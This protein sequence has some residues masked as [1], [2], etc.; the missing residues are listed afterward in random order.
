MRSIIL[1]VILTTPFVVT[2]SSNQTKILS[3]T[4]LHN[5]D[6]H[7]RF[8]QTDHLSGICKL[9]DALA[10]NCFG[11]F[12]RV[13][14]VIKQHRKEAKNGGNPVLYLNAGDTYVGS[15]WF[16]LFKDKIVSE[17]MNIL[18][19]DAMVNWIVK[20]IQIGFSH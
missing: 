1:I 6:M 19:P 10:K 13:S 11:G 20:C 14:S 15:K 4:I 7:G 8:E 18:R 5:N 17:F 16:T 12:A 9:N 2:K 3:L